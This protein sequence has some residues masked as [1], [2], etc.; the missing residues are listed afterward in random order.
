MNGSK[1]YNIV[2]EIDGKFFA[3]TT[4]PSAEYRREQEHD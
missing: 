2:G 1:S 4:E 3:G